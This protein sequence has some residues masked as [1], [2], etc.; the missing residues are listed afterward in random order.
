LATN[1]EPTFGEQAPTAEALFLGATLAKR[2]TVTIPLVALKT[3]VAVMGAAGSGKSWLAKVIAEEAIG[4]GVPVLAIDPQ[5]DLV[6]FLH[7]STLPADAS[8]AERALH[9]EFRRRVEVRIW[10]PG[11]S[12]GQ[13]LSLSPLRLPTQAQL[14]G[15]ESPERRREEWEAMLGV[16]AANLVTLAQAG[17][18]TEVHNTFVLEVLRKLVEGQIDGCQ[19]GLQD[20]ISAIAEPES[21]GVENVDD[22]V[23]KRE[24]DKLKQR[25]NARFRGPSAN[26]F[27]GGTALNLDRFVQAVE[28]GKVP[29]NVVYLNAMPDDS[30]KQYFVA[31]LAA[32]VYRWMITTA[33][34]SPV[35]LLMF[36]DEARDFLPAGA[37]KPP[38]KGPLLRLFAQGRK[39]G[40]SC[41]ICTQSPRSVDYQAFSNA[42]TKLIG[43]LEASQDVD[44]VAEWFTDGGGSPTWLSGRKGASDKA[45]VGRWPEAPAG[46]E[47]EPFRCR[48]LY[49][50]HEG[51]WS[52]DRVET[53]WREHSRNSAF[54][55]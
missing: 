34:T 52:P 36:L 50:L 28:P 27:T 2:A 3:H 38:A 18:D 45:F 53:E 8:P 10:T 39:F 25:L 4:Q 35:R 17:G 16:A 55:A 29:L 9:A 24:R 51:A 22:L 13:R 14:Q 21:F 31:A 12:H 43:R 40:V 30:Q 19:L 5:G 33:S 46:L 49:S 32:K 15:V 47:G 37:S 1:A 44:R 54:Q 23:S 7:A 6:Q 41:L 20:I 11:T 48:R 26:L 42:S